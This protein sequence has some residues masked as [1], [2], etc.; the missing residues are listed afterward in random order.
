MERP[1]R[2]ISNRKNYNA[3]KEVLYYVWRLFN[4]KGKQYFLS[5]E[6][7]FTFR[8]IKVGYIS[9][10]VKNISRDISRVILHFTEIRTPCP[11]SRLVG[12]QLAISLASDWLLS[13][14]LCRVSS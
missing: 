2:T 9:R 8:E 6:M 14:S 7:F 5:R 11:G 4:I 12:W 3:T 1:K 10:N 13:L